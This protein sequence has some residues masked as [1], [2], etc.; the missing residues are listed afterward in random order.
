MQKSFIVFTLMLFTVLALNNCSRDTAG[1]DAGSA[2]LTISLTDAPAAYDSVVIVFSEIS[3]HID[4][5][6]VHILRDPLRVNLLD[7]SNGETFLLGSED[8]PAGKYSQIRLIIDSA[9]VGVN[10]EVHEMFVPSGA[11]T[12]LKLGAHF[13][14]NEG[15]TYSLVLDFDAGRSVVVLS[16]KHNPRGYILKPHIRVVAQAQTG[17]ISGKVL[18]PEAA[19]FAYALVGTDTITSTPVDTTT[20]Y[21]KL[22]FLPEN[23]YTVIVEDTAGKDFSRDSVS[24]QA[25]KDNFLGEIILN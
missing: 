4:S 5:Q 19:P 25:G 6:W 3:A 12:G 10:G 22:A 16:P 9:F 11:Q 24:V 1:L 8:V 13:T 14:V 7:W 23:S 21:F 20:G 17:S 2:T 18:N 15:S